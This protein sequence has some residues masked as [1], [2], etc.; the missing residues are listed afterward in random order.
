MMGREKILLVEDDRV[1]AHDI[2]LELEALGY[3][4]RTT[5]HAKEVMEILDQP[6]RHKFDLLILDIDLIDHPIDEYSDIEDVFRVL[7]AIRDKTPKPLI[8]FTST[9]TRNTDQIV[10]LELGADVYLRKPFDYQILASQ[11]FALLE[12]SRKTELENSEEDLE[13]GEIQVAIHYR[14]T[15]TVYIDSEEV[16]VT[17]DQLNLLYDFMTNPGH[18]FTYEE[19]LGKSNPNRAELSA[20]GSTINRLRTRIRDQERE[21]REEA[22]YIETVRGQGYRLIKR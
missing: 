18:I 8:V 12:R 21:K 1:L 3:N 4:V 5:G 20:L 15:G 13:I 9:R 14:R 19:L 10:G 6:E 7:I 2:K 11:V 22:P 17:D 16:R